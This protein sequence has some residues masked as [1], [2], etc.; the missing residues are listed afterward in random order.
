MIFL[1]QLSIGIF[2][3]FA[4][5]SLFSQYAKAVNLDAQIFPSG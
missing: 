4:D 1:F 5:V 3:D 2:D